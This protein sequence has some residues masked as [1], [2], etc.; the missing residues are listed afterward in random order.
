M[1]ELRINESIKRRVNSYILTLSKIFQL[2]VEVAVFIH[3]LPTAHTALLK[4]HYRAR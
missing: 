3:N 4:S 2:L 1:Y